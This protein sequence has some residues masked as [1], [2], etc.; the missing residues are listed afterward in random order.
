MLYRRI[1]WVLMNTTFFAL[2]ILAGY[3]GIAGAYYVIA[4]LCVLFAFTGVAIVLDENNSKI[5]NAGFAFNKEIEAAY[6]MI[7]FCALL[8]FGFWFLAILYFI[9]NGAIYSVKI[10]D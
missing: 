6:D 4:G 2:I 1:N 8:W 3:Y 10:E 7:T 9:G 5:K